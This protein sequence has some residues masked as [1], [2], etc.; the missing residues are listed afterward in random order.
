MGQANLVGGVLDMLAFVFD[1][2][3]ARARLNRQVCSAQV[4]V[5]GGSQVPY[6]LQG[7]SWAVNLNVTFR[8][9]WVL[10][11]SI[12]SITEPILRLYHNPC[13]QQTEELMCRASAAIT[14]A[15]DAVRLYAG[16]SID[17]GHKGLACHSD[18]CLCCNWQAGE[19][20]YK[21]ATAGTN[22]TIPSSVATGSFHLYCRHLSCKGAASYV[23]TIEAC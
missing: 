12:Y 21:A 3:A 9:Q 5:A 16:E 8:L 1:S 10:V 15:C 4:P 23:Y 7:R 14:T 6:G 13:L 20:A 11:A 18:T 22:N 2:N 17:R 19:F